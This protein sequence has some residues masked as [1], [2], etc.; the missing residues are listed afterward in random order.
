MAFDSIAS[1]PMRTLIAVAA[2]TTALLASASG[3]AQTITAV[4]QSGLRATDPIVSS[5]AISNIHGY[6]IYDTL[7]G[8]DAKAWL[9][10]PSNRWRRL[11]VEGERWLVSGLAQVFGPGPLPSGGK[12]YR[13]FQ[14]LREVSGAG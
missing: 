1:R 13:R 12:N 14:I 10:R 7:L 6:M 11:E 8:T 4:M 3:L 5:A 2:A 9:P